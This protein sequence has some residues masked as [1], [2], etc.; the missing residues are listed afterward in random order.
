MNKPQ[1]KP[2]GEDILKLTLPT[3]RETLGD[4]RRTVTHRAKRDKEGDTM[5]KPKAAW[6]QLTVRL[7]EDVHRALKV[8]VAEEGRNMGE[9]IEGLVRLYLVKGGKP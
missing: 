3:N 2:A 7:P 1:R 4:K 5:K 9:V 8:R 6:K